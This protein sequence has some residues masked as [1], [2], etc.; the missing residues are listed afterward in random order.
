[1]AIYDPKFKQN[2]EGITLQK[3][4]K[5]LKGIQRR[6]DM[7]SGKVE[8]LFSGENVSKLNQDELED[9]V[10]CFKIVELDEE[11]HQLRDNSNKLSALFLSIVKTLIWS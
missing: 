7:K 5:F 6:T 10:P 9:Q 8:L 1:M 2:I 4:N 3:V 11:E